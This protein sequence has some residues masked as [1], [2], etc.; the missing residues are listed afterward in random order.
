MRKLLVG[1]APCSWG[2]LEFE[3]AQGEQIGYS[4]MLDELVETGYTGTELGDWGYMPTEPEVLR[5]ELTRRGLVMLGAFVPVALKDPQAHDAGFACAVKTARL[6]A[7]VTSTPPPYLVLAD[8]NGTDPRRTRLAG[9]IPPGMGLTAAEWN[10]FAGGANRLAQAVL[11]ESGLRTVF[12]HH[13]AG[14]VR[15]RK[16]LP[17][18]WN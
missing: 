1:N 6:L 18:S 5:N 2:T 4:R 8:N 17:G 3:A 9:Q 10:I 7:A 14:Y 15:R 11:E 12:H 16:R 13:C